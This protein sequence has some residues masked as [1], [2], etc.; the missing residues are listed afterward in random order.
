MRCRWSPRLPALR[1]ALSTLDGTLASLTTTLESLD[2]ILREGLKALPGELSRP[3]WWNSVKALAGLSPD[4]AV[5]QS[6][7][8]SVFELNRTLRNLELTRTLE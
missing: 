5:G 7:G 3:W 6:L 2:N 8:N 1:T 4:S